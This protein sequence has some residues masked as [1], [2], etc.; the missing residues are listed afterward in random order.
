MEAE[1][2]AIVEAREDDILRRGALVPPQPPPPPLGRTALAHLSRSLACGQKL[3][4]SLTMMETDYCNYQRPK[5][6]H[7]LVVSDSG[8]VLMH[9]LCE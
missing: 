4:E 7:S 6:H 3:S 5:P 9:L 2:V 1:E 8:I